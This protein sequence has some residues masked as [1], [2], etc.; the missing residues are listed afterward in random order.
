M[1]DGI[2][3]STIAPKPISKGCHR[4]AAKPPAV[5]LIEFTESLNTVAKEIQRNI[6][7]CLRTAEVQAVRQ[8]LHA[9]AHYP[10]FRA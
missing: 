5:G 10:T 1:F 6:N 9:I 7:A 2:D 8:M 4:Q 3:N